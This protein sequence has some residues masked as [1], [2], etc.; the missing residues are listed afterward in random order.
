MGAERGAYEY[1]MLLEMTDATSEFK[2]LGRPRVFGGWDDKWLDWSFTMRAYLSVL[3][4]DLARALERVES[5]TTVV[6]I[7]DVG[8]SRSWNHRV[9]TTN[10]PSARHDVPRTRARNRE[11][12]SSKQRS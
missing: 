11:S 7:R 12:S 1:A 3:S 9:C 8:T 6:T 5:L 2:S 10:I 4:D